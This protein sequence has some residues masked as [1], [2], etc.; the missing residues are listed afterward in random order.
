[1]F[2]SLLF[3]PFASWPTFFHIAILITGTVVAYLA[4]VWLYQL[5]R[6]RHIDPDTAL[7]F[8]L[9]SSF[10][11][12]VLIFSGLQHTLPKIYAF[13]QVFLFGQTATLHDGDA[14][15]FATLA[16]LVS[17]GILLLYRAL[18]LYLFDPSLAM[19][20]KLQVHSIERWILLSLVISIM[21][22]IQ[23]VGVVL[24]SAMVLAPG[25]AARQYTDRLSWMFLLASLFGIVSS[26]V[27]TLISIFA[28]IV[29][30][31]P[32]GPC[33]VLSLVAWVLFS[34]CFAP[35]RGWLCK[36]LRRGRFRRKI[37]RDNLLKALWKSPGL[38]RQ[39]LQQSLHLSSLQLLLQWVELRY[40]KRWVHGSKHSYRLTPSGHRQ[41]QAI[42]RF[43]R[44]WE[45]Y[46]TQ[47]VGLHPF[48]VHQE[49]EEMEHIVTPE[50]DRHLT[51]LLLNPKLDPHQQPIP[52]EDP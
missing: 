39:T 48:S 33:I 5:Q 37:I 51:S 41:A 46:L 21:I 45:L 42:V 7:V 36:W 11:I 20:L 15:M 43:H 12:G 22:A 40:L 38:D 50:L 10:G 28:P 34:L 26:F 17:L 14:L 16:T 19:Q 25:I 27:G 1:M 30:P 52:K 29:P 9:A 32:T 49:A 47:E 44:L 8:V 13:M 4:L 18:Q 31:L 6:Q 35:D 24:V 3:Y 23:S 2:G